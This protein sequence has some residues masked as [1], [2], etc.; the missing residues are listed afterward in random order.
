MGARIISVVDAYDA[1]TSDRPYR[2]GMSPEAAVEQLKAGIGSHFD[3]RI[4]AAFI[5]MLIE[6]GVYVPSS[7]A[8]A[9]HV[10]SEAS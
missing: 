6:D 8:P 2:K 9:L 1:M 3:P 10:V 5:Q 4:C 7:S